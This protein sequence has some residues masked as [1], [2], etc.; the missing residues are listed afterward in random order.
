MTAPSSLSQGLALLGSAVERERSGQ[1]GHN[2]SRLA[3]ATGIE[4]SRVSR[5]TQELRALH[6]LERDETAVL[7]AG[8]AYFR[9]AAALNEP[10]LRAA[11]HELRM[12]ASRL[13]MTALV[14]AAHG[15]GALLL[16]HETGVGAADAAVRPGMITPIWCTGSGRALLW[17]HTPA[18]LDELLAGVQF[19]GVG[20][21][22]AARTVAEV[23][24]LLERD[25]AAGLVTAADEYA[26]GVT[27]HALPIHGS[28]GIVAAIAVSGPPPG[29]AR[30]RAIRTLVRDVR[31]R[32][33]ALAGAR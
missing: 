30:T 10:W 20:G 13:R 4:R 7:S 6:Y 26:E 23:A 1:A 19:V 5:L 31:D 21:P 28:G 11:R 2:A 32:L 9:T 27:E 14:S 12:L 3:D 22:A 17:E 29:E 16:R 8:D 24:S 18:Q 33:S 15:A 25:R